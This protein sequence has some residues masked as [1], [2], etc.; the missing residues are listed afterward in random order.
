MCILLELFWKMHWTYTAMLSVPIRAEK[1]KR[2]V[3][4]FMCAK[5]LYLLYIWD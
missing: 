3:A 4:I 5:S 1:H 2:N